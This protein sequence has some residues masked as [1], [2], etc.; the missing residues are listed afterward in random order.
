M[1]MRTVLEMTK[2]P[3]WK[4]ASDETAI[5]GFRELGK[6]GLWLWPGSAIRQPLGSLKRCRFFSFLGCQSG[7]SIS[8]NLLP[9]GPTVTWT[10]P[11]WV[12]ALR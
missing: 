2:V 11:S 3:R 6:R 8:F 7:D 10:R 4:A 1:E 12:I 9:C 5:P